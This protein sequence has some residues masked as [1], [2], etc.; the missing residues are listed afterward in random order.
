MS[1]TVKERPGV[2]KCEICGQEIYDPYNVLARP[3]CYD[4]FFRPVKEAK[5]W[6]R[7]H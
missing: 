1:S 6:I 3:L 5:A 7:K 4:C 2:K